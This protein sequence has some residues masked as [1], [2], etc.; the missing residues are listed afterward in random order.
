MVVF[1]FVLSVEPYKYEALNTLL[2]LGESIIR[3]GHKIRGIFLFGGGVQSMKKD[4]S[5]GKKKTN[6]QL[7]LEKFCEKNNISIAGCSTWISY[8][9]LKEDSFI[10]GACQVGLPE[11]TDWILESDRLLVF[12]QGG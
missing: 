11:L 1:C 2:S 5:T 12:G 6:L 7:E 4:V 10:K 3:K 9:G 8:T